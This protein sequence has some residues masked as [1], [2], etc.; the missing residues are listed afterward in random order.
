MDAKRVET[1]SARVDAAVASPVL[2]PVVFYVTA[3]PQGNL[4]NVMIA[5]RMLHPPSHKLILPRAAFLGAVI[6]CIGASALSHTTI[7][8]P[9]GA[10]Q[11]LPQTF[12]SF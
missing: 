9:V 8:A 2:S 10:C 6:L 1:V 12:I 7:A 5:R 3:P 11:G 4:K